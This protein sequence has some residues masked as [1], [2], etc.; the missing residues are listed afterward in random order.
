VEA[1][2]ELSKS[3]SKEEALDVEE[4]ATSVFN[5]LFLEHFE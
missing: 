1:D 2:S 3:Q 5:S 4:A